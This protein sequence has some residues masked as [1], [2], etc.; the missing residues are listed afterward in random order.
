MKRTISF[1]FLYLL[2]WSSVCLL[3]ELLLAQSDMLDSEDPGKTPFSVPLDQIEERLNNDPSS[4]GIHLD[5][6]E[7]G[8]ELWVDI[9]SVPGETSAAAVLR[10]IFMLG[11]LAEANYETLIFS[12]QGEKIFSIDG[13]AIRDIGRQ[14]VWGEEGKGQNPIVLVRR[15]VDQL[16]AKS[17]GRAAPEFTGSLL[18]D[19]Q[20]TMEFI[21][22]RFHR[23]WTFKT[24]EIK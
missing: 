15:F 9:E 18:G 23:K 19:T 14:F 1:G 6:E 24:I 5:I 3:P 2:L 21:N 13:Q 16:R 11:R 10:V 12:D 7:N 22:K 8:R 20:K 17:G 4:E